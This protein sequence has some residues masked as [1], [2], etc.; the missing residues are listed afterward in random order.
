MASVTVGDTL[1]GTLAS[2]SQGLG[3][4]A[5]PGLFSI[6]VNNST[7]NANIYYSGQILWDAD[8]AT[9]T[10]LGSSTFVTF[11]T[12]LYTSVTVGTTQTY[13]V[14]PLDEVTSVTN[15]NGVAT[16]ASEE[17]AKLIEGVVTE[18][19]TVS[20]MMSSNL[21]AAQ[22]A[23]A[24]AQVAIWKILYDY[25][26]SASNDY[27]TGFNASTKQVTGGTITWSNST[28][29]GADA[30]TYLAGASSVSNADSM[31]GL[32]SD[33][34]PAVQNQSV[35]AF[36]QSPQTP[37]P[38]APNPSSLAGGGILFAFIGIF[39]YLR[40]SSGTAKP[41]LARLV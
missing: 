16:P 40:R 33:S 2:Q 18:A 31:L 35:L 32:Q 12:Q 39:G 24:G 6:N 1:T 28:T 25:S 27:V 23:S 22:N 4:S 9:K 30:D 37:P 19:N 21:G 10:L 29:W 3:G 7:G 13:T 8:S 14:V 11:C 34:V 26:A 5:A 17:E 36:T 20:G 15:T 38:V 41:A